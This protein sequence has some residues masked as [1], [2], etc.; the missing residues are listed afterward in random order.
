MRGRFARG[1]VL[2]PL[3]LLITLLA[4]FAWNGTANRLIVNKAVDTLPDEMRPFFEANRN[5]LVQ[6]VDDPLNQLAKNPMDKRYHF[7]RLDHYGPF[8]FTSLPRNYK[9][10]VSKYSKHSLETYGLLPWEVGV[11][12][13]R[14][15]NAFRARNWDDVRLSAAHLA[16]YVAAAHDPFNT[17]L[18]DDGKA[19]GQ[20]GVNQRFNSNMVDRYSLFFFV[21]PNQAVYIH[22]PTDHA[23]EMCMSAHSWLENILLADRRARLGLADY[24]D[25]YYDRF[26]SQAGAVLIRQISDAATDVGSYWLTSWT[27]AGK[28]ALPAR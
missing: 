17:T 23:F 20:T 27:N 22:D 11:Y 25:E 10:A 7:I 19:S 12:S 18:N 9:A 16:Y 15:T 24:T 8:P 13:E 1:V 6:H 2:L 4:A 21:H 26:Y 14:L 3:G 28:P 5:Y